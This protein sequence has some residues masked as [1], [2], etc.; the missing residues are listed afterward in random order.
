MYEYS[1]QLPLRSLTRLSAHARITGAPPFGTGA[2]SLGLGAANKRASSEVPYSRMRPSLASTLK[3]SGPGPPTSAPTG[4]MRAYDSLS[5]E[6][7]TGA[8]PR[9]TSLAPSRQ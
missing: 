1:I 7:Q 2:P 3:L 5:V 6:Y 8:V 9:W 4:V